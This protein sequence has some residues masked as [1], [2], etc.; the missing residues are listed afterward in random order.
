MT[1][2]PVD[3]DGIRYSRAMSRA[4]PLVECCAPISRPTLSK[5]QAI[6]LETLFKALADRHRITILN[7]VANMAGVHIESGAFIGVA[8]IILAGVRIGRCSVIAAGAVVTEDVAPYTV[9]AGVP[10][11]VIKT[12][13]ADRLGLRPP[14][15][16]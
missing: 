10:A 1:L 7:P 15:S 13:D 4:L 9:V 6:A 3:I 16:L 2:T 5:A 11:R 14:L 12:L 8:A